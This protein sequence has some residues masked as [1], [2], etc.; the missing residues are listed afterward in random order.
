MTNS[1]PGDRDREFCRRRRGGEWP[2]LITVLG[3]AIYGEGI[4]SVLGCVGGEERHLQIAGTIQMV[5]DY[6]SP[7]LVQ[8]G[9]SRFN[10]TRGK[11]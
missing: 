10:A 7:P 11:K 2:A 6:V 9:N 4:Y 8:E 1:D 5:S 3:W